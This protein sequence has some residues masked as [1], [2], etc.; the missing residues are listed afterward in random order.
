[1]GGDKSKHLEKYVDLSTKAYLAIRKHAKMFIS[2]FALVRGFGLILIKCN[3]DAF[4][5][6]STTAEI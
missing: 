5:W 1:M 4:D 6:N 2:L 3:I